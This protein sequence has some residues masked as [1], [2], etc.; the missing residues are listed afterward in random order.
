MSNSPRT[1]FVSGNFNV[2]HPGHLRLLRFAKECGDRL[3][4]AVQSDRLAAKGA[5]IPEQDRLEGIKSNSWVDEA[6]IIDD[7]VTE[8]LEK[9]KPA[10][11]VKGKEHEAKYNPELKVLEKYGGKLL[12]SS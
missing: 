5:H 3:I 10:I 6:F 12:F 2:L 4:V 8:V 7:P 11:V 1:V 9:L